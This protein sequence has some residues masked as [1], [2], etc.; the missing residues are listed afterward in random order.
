MERVG[1]PTSIGRFRVDTL[2]GRGGM[3]A[4]YRAF[5]PTLQRTVALK[6]VRPD[7]NRPE[8]IKRLI[9]E[10]QAGAQLKHP[11]IVTVYEAGEVDGEVYIAMEYLEGESLADALDRGALT[12]DEKLDALI[13]VL[14]AL[15]HAH[16]MGVV[17][18]DIKSSNVFRLS[19]GSVKLVDFGL[20]R[21]M[22]GDTMTATGPLM[23]TPHFAS[24][25][26]L[27]G[28]PIDARTDIYSAGTLAYA[29]LA[30]RLPF[31]GTDDTISSV[32][33]RVISQPPPPID[34]ADCRDL[35]E[36]EQIVQ[37]A[38]A[39]SPLERFASA[40]DMKAA[41][42]TVREAKSAT[43]SERIKRAD[44]STLYL[45]PTQ[46]LASPPLLTPAQ[47]PPMPV[48]PASRPW[49]WVAGAAVLGALV[50]AVLTWPTAGR[51]GI[52]TDSNA[53]PDASEATPVPPPVVDPSTPPQPVTLAAASSGAE[54][55]ARPPGRVERETPPPPAA[56]READNVP[57]A[58]TAK[59]LYDGTPGAAAAAPGTGLKY[60]LLQQSEGRD[61]DVDP[62]M[63]FRTGDRV[64]FVFESNIDGF[65]YVVLRGSSGRWSVLFPHPEINGGRHAIA[66][67]Q[68]YAVPPDDWFAFDA[69]PGT[70]D[71]M[72]FLSRDAIPQMP[73]FERP[74]RQAEN[75]DGAV[76]DQLA[77]TVRPRD[78][79]L[80]RTRAAAGPNGAE[81]ATYVVNRAEAGKAVAVSVSLRHAP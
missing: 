13:Q 15:D 41:V 36:L 79:I 24:P 39:K 45:P 78:L 72:V 25:E 22:H 74:V 38:M 63:T 20:A 66:K 58:V 21:V 19:D 29:M 33:F 69:T 50:L 43:D 34:T 47:T 70:E 56:A 2:L 77:Q 51:D 64:R 67:G 57:A 18:R 14:D 4:V 31:E 12:I 59:Q 6:T 7:I 27:K 44:Q 53:P 3:G 80:E 48:A 26:Q 17:H 16:R 76:V 35:P 23:G 75:I 10:A 71:V 28:E 9:R 73:G 49:A 42:A 5:D 30:G 1:Q 65:L 8:Y 60:R 52:A 46:A 62:S 40:G 61:I 81:Q 32:M 11:N 55:S 54:P 37:R 68:Q